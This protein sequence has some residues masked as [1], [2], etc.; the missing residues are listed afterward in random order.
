MANPEPLAHVTSAENNQ[1]QEQIHFLLLQLTTCHCVGKDFSSSFFL[2]FI[3]FFFSKGREKVKNKVKENKCEK[4]N[5]GIRTCYNNTCLI[6]YF[7]SLLN[8]IWELADEGWNTCFLVN[9][10]NLCVFP[11]TDGSAI[12]SSVNLFLLL[13]F[14][15][16]FFL[17]FFL[18]FILSLQVSRFTC[19]S[20]I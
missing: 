16:H 7:W 18:I 4:K 3:F 1:V 12:I 5:Q 14:L 17:Y 20:L 9:L 10:I 19:L 13:L 8:G 2:H 11:A 6:L 15:L